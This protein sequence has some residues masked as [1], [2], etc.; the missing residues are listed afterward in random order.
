MKRKIN[1]IKLFINHDDK[2][3]EVG[4]KLLVELKKKHFNIVDNNY[5]LVISIGG[6]GTFLHMVKD[7]NFNNE[8]YYVGINSGTVGF[9]QEIDINHT[10]DFV[11]RLSQDDYKE[12]E[13]SIEE[14]KIIT[15][16]DNKTYYS[17]NEIVLRK[18][19]FSLLKMPVY[20]DNELL[21][22][23]T[24][25]GLLI[26]TSTGSTAYNMS[27]GGSII[28]NSLK[29]LTITPIAPLNNKA[30]KTLVNPI[31]VPENKE[32]K[33]LPN[34]SLFVMIDGKN[35]QIKDVLEIRTKVASRKI[36]CI[37]MHDF[38]F[39]KTVNSKILENKK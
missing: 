5:D 16:K 31:I 14:T 9:L 21:E 24:G 30:Y 20:I 23:F 32:I 10:L 8:I 34:T 17:L 25:D 15:Q 13:L 12:E 29:A 36:K 6:D 39:I 26:S 27:F 33:V 11:E 28:Y 35:I 7:E 37:R 3:K 19:D 22:N 2:S 18:D 38:H 4:E 1:N